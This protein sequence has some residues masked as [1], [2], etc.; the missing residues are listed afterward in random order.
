MPIFGTCSS[1]DTCIRPHS[2]CTESYPISDAYVCYTDNAS[3]P[4]LFIIHRCEI[5]LLIF[6]YGVHIVQ[7]CIGRW[8]YEKVVYWVMSGTIF[9]LVCSSP[10]V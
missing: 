9:G 8:W 10:Y 4:G 7:R 3:M 5:D 6:M 2:E 1:P